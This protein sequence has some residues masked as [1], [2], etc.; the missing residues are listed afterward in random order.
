MVQVQISPSRTGGQWRLL[1]SLASSSIIKCVEME[2][3]SSI[4]SIG[5]VVLGRQVNSESRDLSVPT[6][7]L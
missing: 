4:V 1:G 3:E 2:V 7:S 5:I 6:L